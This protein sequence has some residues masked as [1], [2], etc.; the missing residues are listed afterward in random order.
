MARKKLSAEPKLEDMNALLVRAQQGDRS[1]LPALR[2]YL[3]SHPELW[4]QL[5]NLAFQSQAALVEMAAGKS[6]IV[7]EAVFRRARE[8]RRELLGASPTPLERLVVGRIIVGWLQVH[9][10]DALYARTSGSATLSQSDC[11]RRRLEG[12]QRRYL[13]A[14]RAL[15]VVRRLQIPIVQVNIADRQVNVAQTSMADT[16]GRHATPRLEAQQ[17]NSPHL[18]RLNGVS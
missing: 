3:D 6:E 16:H 13:A 18:A 5:G 10:A 12:A 9:H 2:T 11:L 15:A 4:R 17:C 8:L 7:Q 1:V 14:I